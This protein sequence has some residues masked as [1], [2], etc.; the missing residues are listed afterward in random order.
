MIHSIIFTTLS[1]IILIFD[2]GQETNTD[3]TLNSQKTFSA[4]SVEVSY[5]VSFGSREKIMC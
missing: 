5:L 3:Q 1:V 4:L 2:D